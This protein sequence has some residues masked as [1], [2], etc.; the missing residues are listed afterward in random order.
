MDAEDERKELRSGS[1]VVDAGANY[2][3]GGLGRKTAL[4]WRREQEF[5]T[6]SQRQPGGAERTRGPWLTCQGN[7]EHHAEGRFEC[8][9]EMYANW[10]DGRDLAALW[11]IPTLFIL[12]P[13]SE[14]T[15]ACHPLGFRNFAAHAVGKTP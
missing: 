12:K 13:N 11:G 6:S 3:D 5:C 9:C 15:S 14:I 8:T 2:C 10:E 7:H 4:G 1:W